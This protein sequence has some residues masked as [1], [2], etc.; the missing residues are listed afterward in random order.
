MKNKLTIVK[1]V[2][3]TVATCVLFCSASANV[4]IVFSDGD[5]ELTTGSPWV[6]DTTSQR[7]DNGSGI[8]FMDNASITLSAVPEPSSLAVLGLAGI[9]LVFRRRK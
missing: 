3:M 1:N 2:A 7:D 8:S 5:F 4:D 9:A 6:N